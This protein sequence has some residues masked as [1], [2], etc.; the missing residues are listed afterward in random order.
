M[1]A[2]QQLPQLHGHRA[3][4]SATLCSEVEDVYSDLYSTFS[5]LTSTTA[6]DIDQVPCKLN[7]KIVLISAGACI[8]GLLFG[9]DTGVISGVLLVIA[10]QDI[11]QDE[12]T[13]FQKELITSITCLGS[14]I[15]SI[16]G[17][18]LSDRYGRRMTMAFCCVIFVLGGVWMAL[19][20]TLSLLVSGRLIVGVAVGVAAQCVPVYLTEVAPANIRG[21]ML[22]L[23]S[24]AITGGQLLS[25]VSAL[26]MSD[27]KHAW[28]Y[29]FGLSAIPAL[30]FLLI[31]EFI[32]E[33]P[34]W[35]V[36]K[37]EFA[38][39]HATLRVM[40]PTASPRQ[41]TLK[42]RRLVL[43]LCKL[44]KY[45]DV[46]EPLI[47]RPNL[48]ARYTRLSTSI[49]TQEANTDGHSG[50]VPTSTHVLEERGHT[51][52]QKHHMEPRARRALI[53]GC[54]LMFFQQ[55]SGFNAFMYYATI[56]FGDLE[57]QNPLVPATLIALTNFLFTLVAFRIVDTIGKRSMLLHTVWIMTASLLLSCLAFAN[58]SSAWVL[59]SITLFVAAFASAMGT[60]PWSSVEFLPLNRRSFGASCI[61]CTNW[62]TNMMMSVSFLSVVNYL[63]ASHTMLIF[64]SVTI[65]NWL[66]VY[67][68][69]PE[70]KGLTLEE[71]G[72]VFEHGIDVNYVYRNYH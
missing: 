59:F 61:S 10:P 5:Q 37:G 68:W 13:D 67:Y 2:E 54:V 25:Y 50:Y 49:N 42:L 39:A 69:Y 17:F 32:P 71:I 15:G 30:I 47:A 53:V 3:R 27:V 58:G 36:L 43:D 41:I 56:I 44:R 31:F 52:R 9:Y 34:R 45:E 40:H 38:R 51:K 64:A 57:M 66:F 63:G 12:I 65:L 18:P 21:T 24:M 29:L 22:T 23:N 46:E 55:A 60:V 11:S 26:L 14:F 7:S 35:L 8:C 1:E 20:T 62:L 48:I 16:M 72:K 33:S 28:R 4:S 19:S 70:V 6:N